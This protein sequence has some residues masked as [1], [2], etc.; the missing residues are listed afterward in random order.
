MAKTLRKTSSRK[1]SSKHGHLIHPQPHQSWCYLFRLFPQP[2]KQQNSNMKQLT[3]TLKTFYPTFLPPWQFP[4]CSHSFLQHR[5]PLGLHLL[6]SAVPEIRYPQSPALAAAL[7]LSTWIQILVLQGTLPHPKALFAGPDRNRLSQ[8]E[9]EECNVFC[10]LLPPQELGGSNDNQ[11]KHT[12]TQYIDKTLPLYLWKQKIT[13]LEVVSKIKR[14][15]KKAPE[16]CDQIIP[17]HTKNLYTWLLP[18]LF[19]WQFY[20][21]LKIRLSVTCYTHCSVKKAILMHFKVLYFT[22][23]FPKMQKSHCKLL[24]AYLGALPFCLI[25]G[26]AAE[27]L[28]YRLVQQRQILLLQIQYKYL[29]CLYPT[30]KPS[31]PLWQEQEAGTDSGAFI[32]KEGDQLNT[33]HQD[34]ILSHSQNHAQVPGSVEGYSRDLA[35]AYSE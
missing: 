34:L 11:A 5:S 17:P 16:W 3:Y 27:K 18:K 25:A 8:V 31:H 7:L 9:E 13:K 24:K 14:R 1:I 2:T 6:L 26:L 21:L 23:S 29:Y 4:P 32:Q 12:R 35:L 28:M 30:D 19:S 10:C 33:S 15:Q 20:T 22:G